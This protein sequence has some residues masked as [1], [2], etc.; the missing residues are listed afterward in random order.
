M[1]RV[2]TTAVSYI[3]E[4]ARRPGVTRQAARTGFEGFVDDALTYTEAEFSVANALRGDGGGAGG[5]VVDRL[6][7]DSDAVRDHVLAPELEAYRDQVLTQF[8]VLLDAVEAGDD[9]AAHREA[10]L[11]ADVYAQNLEPG[12]H[13]DRREPVTERLFDRQRGLA[14]AVRRSSRL[15]RTTSPSPPRWRTTTAPSG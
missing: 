7:K 11:A 6:L 10:I 3:T 15:P 8:G 14:S 9:P 4:P 1:R 2:D 5:K 12:L 13:P